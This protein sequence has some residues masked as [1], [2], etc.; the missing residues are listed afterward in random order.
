MFQLVYEENLTEMVT[1]KVNEKITPR[2]SITKGIPEI[3]DV[4]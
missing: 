1:I 3:V 2:S 4:R